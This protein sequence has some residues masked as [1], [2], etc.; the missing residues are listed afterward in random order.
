MNAPDGD[1]VPHLLAAGAGVARAPSSGSRP[2]VTGQ[3]LLVGEHGERQEEVVPR[4]D[5]RQQQHRHDRGPQQ[6]QRDLEEGA[7]LAGAVDAG[8]LE[9]LVGHGVLRVDPHQVD[10]E[11]AEQRRQ[12]DGPRRVDD[13]VLAEQHEGRD[14]EGGQRH[15]DRAEDDREDARR[16][17]G[18]GTSRSRSRRGSRASWRRCRRRRRRGR[19]CRASAS[20]CRPGG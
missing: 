1:E 5:D 16:G 12:D 13:A 9:H 11:R 18:S 14:D 20:R 17:R 10:A 3:Q 15:H 19:S 6:R 4:A 8:G 2:T 7:D